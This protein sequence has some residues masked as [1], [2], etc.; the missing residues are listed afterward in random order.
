MYFLNIIYLL[1][2]NWEGN[3]IE[4]LISFNNRTA[5]KRSPNSWRWNGT[6]GRNKYHSSRLWSECLGLEIAIKVGRNLAH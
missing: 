1:Y 4:T 6:E 3:H 2:K 5:G